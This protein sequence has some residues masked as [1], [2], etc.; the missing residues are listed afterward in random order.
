MTALAI[1]LGLVGR[2]HQGRPR[3]LAWSA[4]RQ[5]LVLLYILATGPLLLLLGVGAYVDRTHALSGAHR[6]AENIAGMGAQQQDEMMQEAQNLLL[7]LDLIPAVRTGGDACHPTLRT[8]EEAHPHIIGLSVL[9]RTGRALCNSRQ[10]R[11]TLDASDRLYFRKAMASLPGDTVVSEI[12]RSRVSGRP[13]MV[14]A[15]AFS[16]TPDGPPVRV[17][18]ALLNLDWFPWL[19][20]RLSGTADTVV[21]IVDITTGTIVARSAAGSVTASSSP[22]NPR[23]LNAIHAFP[24]GSSIDADVNDEPHTVAFAPLPGTQGRLALLIAL[25]ETKVLAPSNHHLT[26]N[27][28][29]FLGA[30]IAAVVLAWLAADR[31]LL[32]PIRQLAAA[33][34]S[35]GSGDLRARS[36]GLS[37]AVEEL[38]TLG[39]SFDTM[40]ERLR[41]RDERIAAMGERI[42]QS[43]EHHRLLANNVGDMIARFDR[44]FVRTYIS[45]ASRE[46]VGYEPE[47]MLG[48]AMAEIVLDEDR[49]RVR[50][51]LVRPLLAGAETAR[52]T[53]RVQHRDGQVIWLEA[54]GR[55]LPDGSGFVTVA[56]DVSIQ[57]ALETQLEAANHKLRIQ[58]MQD[59]LTGIA[60]RRRFDEMLGF[61]FRRAQRLQEPLSL[62]MVD[63]DH[64][65]S[66]ND[67]FGHAVGDECLRLVATALDRTLRRPGDLVGRYGGEEFAILLPGTPLAGLIVLA[68]RVREAVARCSLPGRAAAAGALTV[69]VG[70]ATLMPPVGATG[71]AAGMAALVETADAAL[72]KAKR[73]GRNCVMVSAVPTHA[74]PAPLPA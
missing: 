66:F 72:Y 44:N 28:L 13:S 61:E 7:V 41:A 16:D 59:P 56:R 67:R 2:D 37:G 65:K 29:G 25:P 60:N 32:R 24:A 71:Q 4:A 18:T 36:G 10:E 3:F 45:P 20:S 12:I 52:C 69:S 22:A 30:A 57:K 53:Y 73:N 49:Q 14:V 11:P 42:A 74:E 48:H 43:E 35:I 17:I 27:L 55:R 51:E 50:T 8:I 21:E 9:D 15:R 26:L 23:L 40:A 62:L 46:V 39:A 54:F 68:E 34:T 5:R 1:R 31:S 70:A 63:I 19:A 33:A 47:I 38:K 58:V 6:H 64:F